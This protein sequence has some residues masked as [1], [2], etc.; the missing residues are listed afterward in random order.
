[1]GRFVT[2]GIDLGDLDVDTEGESDV[3]F[4][5]VAG[6][7]W[8]KR[9]ELTG[10]GDF[11]VFPYGC[12]ELL[13]A[14]ELVCGYALTGVDTCDEPVCVGDTL[15]FRPLYGAIATG[16]ASRTAVQVVRPMMDQVVSR[17]GRA[18]DLQGQTKD[19]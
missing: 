7:F 11:G 17:Q 6:V 16:M 14:I 9:V 19:L 4:D 2:D 18:L 1:M 12:K 10:E 5:Q 8:P 13:Y 15:V 3:L